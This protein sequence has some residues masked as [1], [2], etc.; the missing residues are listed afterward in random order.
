MSLFFTA[1]LT[2]TCET[3]LT[4]A[5]QKEQNVPSPVAYLKPHP[6]LL[7]LKERELS[8]NILAMQRKIREGKRQQHEAGAADESAK[9][10]KGNALALN[11][12]RKLETTVEDAMA[13]AKK[14]WKTLDLEDVQP[15]D[16]ERMDLTDLSPSL[17]AHP[18]G[19]EVDCTESERE[20]MASIEKRASRQ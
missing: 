14:N 8:A 9:T 15:W 17:L 3:R 1:T 13:A 11:M 4:Q 18:T 16:L 5:V 12:D 10:P 7:D 2:I 19:S 6:H 20:M